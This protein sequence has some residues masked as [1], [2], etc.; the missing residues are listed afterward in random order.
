MA[1][2]WESKQGGA[3][4]RFPPPLIF[5]AALVGGWFMPDLRV[6][7]GLIRQLVAI[8]AIVVALWLGAGAVR[9]FRKTGQNP[10]PWLPT[11]SLV[12]D[13]PYR[14]TR[15]PMYVG[16]TLL[17]LGIGGLAGRGWI[18]IFACVALG[19][20]HFIAVLPE[21][22]Y[23]TEKFGDEYTQYMQRVRRYF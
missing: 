20:V 1:N 7:V 21:E 12:L 2:R 13:G 14:Y 19:L 23:L 15:N 18:L 8:A 5:L 10:R 16:L 4:V 6:S 11:P 17:V 9:L 22:R 3:R